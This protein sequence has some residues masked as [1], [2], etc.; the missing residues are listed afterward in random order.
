[1]ALFIENLLE[2]RWAIQV[3]QH[4]LALLTH[5]SLRLLDRTKLTKN[6]LPDY[7]KDGT[8]LL[9]VPPHITGY[10]QKREHSPWLTRP[11]NIHPLV[12]CLR[13]YPKWLAW[14]HY[15]I[16]DWLRDRQEGGVAI[17]HYFH[18]AMQMAA[19]PLKIA[20]LFDGFLV[21]GPFFIDTETDNDN[22]S[23]KEFYD[24]R[25]KKFVNQV[26]ITTSK[27]QRRF[28]HDYDRNELMVLGA[29]RGGI[30]QAQLDKKI[31]MIGEVFETIFNIES[32]ASFQTKLQRC[33][34]NQLAQTAF[35]LN[36]DDVKKIISEL[37]IDNGKY[38]YFDLEQ[39][40]QNSHLR[41]VVEFSG[42]KL[43]LKALDPKTIPGKK[44]WVSELP[45][46]R[47]I[48]SETSTTPACKKLWE[49]DRHSPQLF[50]KEQKEASPDDLIDQLEALKWGLRESYQTLH[51]GYA[52]EIL[53]R[54]SNWLNNNFGL[55]SE[56]RIEGGEKPDNMYFR[57]AREV[58]NLF[59][60]DTTQIYMYDYPKQELLN[61]FIFF[62]DKLPSIERKARRDVLN[63]VMAKAKADETGKLRRE[64]ISYRCADRKEP[65]FSR[66]W[67]PDTNQFDPP[68]QMFLNP[69][70]E[71]F[72]K[73]IISV[74]MIVNRRLFGVVEIAGNSPYQFR[75][76]NQILAE[77]VANVLGTF[78]YQK[79]VM[80]ALNRLSYMI[81]DGNQDDQKKYNL[82]C[83]E[84]T[85]IFGADGSVLYVPKG[86]RQDEFQLAGYCNRPDLEEFSEAEL[87]NFILKEGE[88]GSL[89]MKAFKS[90]KWCQI[91]IF[92]LE[93]TYP[94]WST[95]LPERRAL[96][97]LF[98]WQV[99]IPVYDLRGPGKNRLGGVYLYFRNRS[100]DDPLI[101]PLSDRWNP[102]VQFMTHY[103]A[104][105]IDAMQTQ[106]KQEE[107]LQN[108]LRHE[109]RQTV[110][111]VAQRAE[112]I[113]NYL[114][115]FKQNFAIALSRDDL[116]HHINDRVTIMYKDLLASQKLLSEM[117]TLLQAESFRNLMTSGL[118]P[119]LYLITQGGTINLEEAA[120][121][122]ELKALFLEIWRSM[123]QN[124][125]YKRKI[126]NFINIKTASGL[127]IKANKTV[128]R[129]I[130]NN[131]FFNAAKYSLENSDIV[132][133]V[134]DTNGDSFIIHIMN[135]AKPID[136]NEKESI[137]EYGF[138][139]KNSADIPGEGFGL[140][141][142]RRLC[143]VLGAGLE[144]DIKEIR[145]GESRFDF[146]V[147]L[148]M[149]IVSKRSLQA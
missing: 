66:A 69:K 98:A 8:F 32:D 44:I 109:L 88:A 6:P 15:F 81:L 93:K 62:Q 76:A 91:G 51:K 84:L 72:F 90:E 148:P 27:P 37:N 87:G 105:L 134:N 14:E 123:Q 19:Y 70:R 47:Q 116:L 130:F 10:W 1:M 53:T 83:R 13:R 78:L 143:E 89:L 126:I 80:G 114:K 112:D 133:S 121:L 7:F 137:F 103:L 74:P 43:K 36:R 2:N 104:L 138:R 73:S 3:I 49:K 129:G 34:F 119:I 67:D 79:E 23:D 16:A 39:R 24:T 86:S 28:R 128:I 25:V 95:R 147:V 118:D 142:T 125:E 59:S 146:K 48:L 52:N 101:E 122:I 42:V 135:E 108:I 12:Q 110:G 29:S 5:A 11:S 107:K 85:G 106:K 61:K 30:K 9:K 57:I 50:S 64:S 92:E 111:S 139:G 82:I 77:D 94:G 141:Y 40:E 68:Y 21:V 97:D 33:T 120:D 20:N 31:K 113:V 115:Q 35:L 131:L 54:F 41:V 26:I 18:E 58:N 63:D 124:P 56:A 117:V 60:A 127:W 145:K 46:P 144:L 55:V 99:A 132:A 100:D 17:C 4:V 140:A 75:F 149:R 102:T 136:P 38:L 71:P 96:L 22:E 65:C 45:P